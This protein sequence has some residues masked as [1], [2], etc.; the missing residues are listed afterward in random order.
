MYS[1]GN[2][3]Q[4]WGFTQRPGQKNS[5]PFLEWILK[6]AGCLVCY[7]KLSKPLSLLRSLLN[8]NKAQYVDFDNLSLYHYLIFY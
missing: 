8:F 2:M 1:G 4:Y 7:L 5:L 6:L 3:S